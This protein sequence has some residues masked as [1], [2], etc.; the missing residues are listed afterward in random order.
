M[1]QWQYLAIALALAVSVVVPVLTPAQPDGPTGDPP[2]DLPSISEL[3]D[4]PPDSLHGFYRQ[5]QAE[6]RKRRLLARLRTRFPDQ[7][8]G[9]LRKKY[10]LMVN[11]RFSG[12]E[13]D[14]VLAH[15]EDLVEVLRE[16]P[17]RP[18]NRNL[19][20]VLF[21]PTLA[22]EPEVGEPVSLAIT[23]STIIATGQ[24]VAAII[25]TK[26]LDNFGS[27]WK[28]HTDTLKNTAE[29]GV[30]LCELSDYFDAPVTTVAGTAF[31]VDSNLVVTAAHVADT[32]AFL[33]DHRFVFG[34]AWLDSVTARVD[35]VDD[36]VYQGKSINFWVNDGGRDIALI[37]LER[38]VVGRSPVKLGW[39]D[40]LASTDDVY[41]IGYPHG[42]PL[43]Y[44]D[45]GGVIDNTPCSFF[46]CDL[47]IAEF[48]SGSPVFNSSHAAVGVVNFDY[49]NARVYCDCWADPSYTVSD[50]RAGVIATR[51][52]VV[53]EFLDHGGALVFN[54]FGEDVTVFDDED[55]VERIANG[56]SLEF[57]AGRTLQVMVGEDCLNEFTTAGGETWY[58]AE[59]STEGTAE[60]IRCSRDGYSTGT[61]E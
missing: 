46:S 17:G 49:A 57:P 7:E 2:P 38:D 16:R 60:L 52:G 9:A 12:A 28:I 43:T 22:P 27:I 33:K 31:L 11:P 1:R 25:H 53:A 34:Y 29:G 59:G 24:A 6:L 37:E 54:H 8:A 20:R 15:R 35:L 13:D 10:G 48:N 21:E 41:A 18:A 50:G 58:I 47:E 26:D 44:T 39:P 45:A 42:L 51:V 4:L 3:S 32:S 5:A 36:D 61:I 55:I 30:L 14:A 56:E 19:R 40:R 23:D